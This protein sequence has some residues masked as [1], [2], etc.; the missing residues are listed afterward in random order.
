MKSDK[1]KEQNRIYM[2]SYRERKG[3]KEKQSEYHKQWK[4]DNPDNVKVN[5]K[6][7]KESLKD[8]FYTVYYLKEDHYVGQTNCLPVRLEKHKRNGRHILDA[9][10]LARFETRTE[11]LAF[12]SR[13]HDMGY[14]GR[15]NGL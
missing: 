12:E 6:N 8:G 13:L 7:Y 2:Q 5:R 4:L 11:A 9:E 3:M 1:E 10:V 15:N 14:H